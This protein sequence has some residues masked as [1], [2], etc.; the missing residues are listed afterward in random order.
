MSPDETPDPPSQRITTRRA[1]QGRDLWIA[2]EAAQYARVIFCEEP[3]TDAERDVQTAFV[4]T[5]TRHLE[6]WAETPPLGQ[7]TALEAVNQRLADLDRLG[8]RV[9]WGVAERHVDDADAL[10]ETMPLAVLIVDRDDSAE[11]TV[12]LPLDLDMDDDEDDDD[13]DEDDEEDEDD[14]DLTGM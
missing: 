13:D 5:L 3:R 1:A 4:D 8:F 7:A 14:D 12:D 9:H 2:I 10:E 6:A 11:L